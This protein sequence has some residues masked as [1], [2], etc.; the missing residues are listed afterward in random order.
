[1]SDANK[2]VL[3]MVEQKKITAAVEL[4]GGAS[5]ACVVVS[6]ERPNPR[7]AGKTV[8]VAPE[9]AVVLLEQ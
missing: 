7:P 9:S 5:G 4:E 1:M 2:K 6:P 8:I 3:E